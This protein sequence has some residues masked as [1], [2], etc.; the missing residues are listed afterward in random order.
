MNYSQEYRMTS[1][2]RSYLYFAYEWLIGETASDVSI[3]DG[4]A[5]VQANGVTI[6]S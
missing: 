3:L 6:P 5:V 2:A 4:R 1:I